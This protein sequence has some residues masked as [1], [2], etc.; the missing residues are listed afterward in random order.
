[1]MRAR[2]NRIA[3]V[4]MAC[5][6]VFVCLMLLPALALAEE[7]EPFSILWVPDTQNTVYF[8][9]KALDA[10]ADWILENIETENIV[11]VVHTG[12]LV[13]EGHHKREWDVFNTHFYQR[14]RDSIPFYP[15]AGNHDLG[16]KTR[17]W[18]AYLAEDCVRNAVPKAQ[19][20]AQGKAFYQVIEAGGRKLLL[21]GAGYGA[22]EAAAPFLRAAAEKNPDAYGILLVHGYI[23][24]DGK[25]REYAS[26]IKQSII[27]P[28]D[29][30][31]L[32]LCGHFRGTAFETE[33]YDAT[34]SSPA[35]D[36]SVMMCNYQGYTHNSGQMR[37]LTFDPNTFDIR[38]R[39]FSALTGHGM[40]DAHFKSDTFTLEGAFQP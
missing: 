33:Q 7:E 4:H 11:C 24:P 36:V 5:A 37:L 9:P 18:D 20:F 29:R 3:R 30:I 32:V 14:I 23:H 26:V 34:A 15:I 31:R 25:R 8:E 38:V 2:K 27:E 16:V 13:N 35:R 12:D 28:I 40:R 19:T 21:L 17:L 39:T 22:E 10:M 1:M 6:L